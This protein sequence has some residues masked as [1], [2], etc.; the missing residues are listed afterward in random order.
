MRD[1]QHGARTL[2]GSGSLGREMVPRG[3]IALLLAVVAVAL[4]ACGGDDDSASNVSPTRGPTGQQGTTGPQSGANE[5]ARTKRAR[6]KRTAKSRQRSDRKTAAGESN[7]GAAAPAA[8]TAKQQKPKPRTLTPEELKQL[9]PQQY[10]QARVLCKASTLEGLAQ[11]HGIKS[12][13][14]DEVAEA[15]AAQYLAGLRDAVEAGCK[16]GLLESK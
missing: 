6:P 10:E 11:H 2:L 12:G 1:G 7:T 4:G 14:P 16:A 15:Y 3:C 13:D 5:T 8:P 9:E